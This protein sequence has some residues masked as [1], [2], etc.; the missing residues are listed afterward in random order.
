MKQLQ[1]VKFIPPYNF[2]SIFMFY[3]NATNRNQTCK[4]AFIQDLL[5]YK[6]SYTLFFTCANLCMNIRKS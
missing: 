1:V 4:K 3:L 2:E 6:F 5:R